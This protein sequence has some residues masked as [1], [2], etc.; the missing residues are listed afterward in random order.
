MESLYAHMR[1]HGTLTETPKDIPDSVF[2]LPSTLNWMR[3]KSILVQD[4]ATNFSTAKSF[5]AKVQRKDL[6]ERQVNSI[7]EQLLFSL[8]QVA[9]LNGLALVPNKADVARVGIVTWYYGV[10]G[11]A[12]AM[13]AAADGSFPATH[14]ATA[15][16]WDRQFALPK[17]AMEPFGDRLSSLVSHDIENELRVPRSRGKHALTSVPRTVEQAWGCHAEY[18]S[19]T[20]NWEKWNVEQRVRQSRDFKALGVSDFRKKPARE[21]RDESLRQ[22]SICFLH[23]ASRYRGKANYRDAIYLAYGTSVPKL[24]AGFIDDLLTVLMAFAAMAGAYC[25]KRMGR[26]RWDDFVSCLEKNRAI[27]ISPSAVWA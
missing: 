10:Y 14:A 17:L 20:A 25:S 21:L 5:Y 24:A 9:A 16:Q 12:S 18:L 8:H 2:A 23:E 13:I 19:G 4:C 3:A 26:V 15:L 27:S 22:K 11:A 6:T 7:Y 1:K